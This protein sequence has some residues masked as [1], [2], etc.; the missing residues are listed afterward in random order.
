MRSRTERLLSTP[1]AT[2][3]GPGPEE[4]ADGCAKNAEVRRSFIITTVCEESQV[5]PQGRHRKG[6]NWRPTVS[7]SMPLPTWTSHPCSLSWTGS[8]LCTPLA[9]DFGPGPEGAVEVGAAGWGV[10]FL[11]LSPPTS[12]LAHRGRRRGVQPELDGKFAFYASRRRLRA[13]RGGDG[14]GVRNRTGSLLVISQV[15]PST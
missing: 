4:A 15:F 14:G 1:H 7:N 3:S 5:T 10:S 13:W 8:L 9:A 6:S 11:R 2:D 12:G